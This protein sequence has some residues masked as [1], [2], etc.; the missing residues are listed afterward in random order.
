MTKVK[1]VCRDC[2]EPMDKP[3]DI[4]MNCRVSRIKEREAERDRNYKSVR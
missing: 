3:I 1:A 4:C 2:G